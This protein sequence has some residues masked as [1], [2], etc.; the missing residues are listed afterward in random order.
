MTVVCPKCGAVNE[1]PDSLNRKTRYRCHACDK[2]LSGIS[3]T[4][5]GIVA[6]LVLMAWWAVPALAW[7]SAYYERYDPAVNEV[8]HL[9]WCFFAL[10]IPIGV[11]ALAITVYFLAAGLRHRK[12]AGVN[13]RGFRR[14]V[15]IA[16]LGACTCFV[17]SGLAYAW[18]RW[19][20]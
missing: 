20:S 4:N 8:F 12:F 18:S 10:S 17:A 9:A 1:L 13:P 2:W 15:L 11:T 6:A 19:W 3:N 14:F 7:A 5:F 16:V